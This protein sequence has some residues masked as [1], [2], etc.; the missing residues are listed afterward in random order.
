M[1]CPVAAG[2]DGRGNGR[3]GRGA[4]RGGLRAGRSGGGG[5]RCPV[6]A[7]HDGRGTGRDGRG[8]G[9]G[10]RGARRGGV[11]AGRSGGGGVGCPVG[12]GHDNIYEGADR[13]N[14]TAEGYRYD[15]RGL[16]AG[17]DQGMATGYLPKQGRHI[18]GGNHFQESV[19]SIV[20][21]TP[22]LAGRVVE[23]QAPGSAERTDGGFVK[24][25]LTRDAEMVLVVKKDQPQD[26]PEVVDPVG[27]VERHAPAVRL[28][29]KT[30]Q[31]KDAFRWPSPCLAA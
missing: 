7:G 21:Q 27:I 29:R 18:G 15:F 20:L 1:R 13:R 26:A 17:G 8:T 24:T 19:G 22:H 9:R 11:R 6:A 16:L 23:G 30:P 14:G 12:V 2:H 5:V 10:G 31:E 4:R 25:F 3:G 28:G